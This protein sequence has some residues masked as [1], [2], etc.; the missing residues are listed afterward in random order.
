M[1]RD[2]TASPHIDLRELLGERQH[3]AGLSADG[4]GHLLLL[5]MEVE[6]ERNYLRSYRDGVTRFRLHH[7]VP[8]GIRTVEFHQPRDLF[9]LAQPLGEDH[10]LL[11]RGRSE[12]DDDPNAHLYTKSGKYVRSFPA[13]DGIADVQTT[14]G[15]AIWVSYFD[16]GV[17]S[18]SS[19]LGHAGLAC[20][21]ATDDDPLAYA[22]SFRFNQDLARYDGRGTPDITDCYA[23]NVTDEDVWLCYFGGFPLVRLSPDGRLRR[24]W[25]EAPV[26]GAK[27]IAT[28]G[29]KVLFAGSYDRKDRLFLWTPDNP[30]RVEELRAR[31]PD[32]EALTTR[33]L[34]LH[35]PIARGSR[36][37][38]ADDLARVYLI[39]LINL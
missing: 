5:S 9:S 4:D 8:P 19:D 6:G 13:G 37:Y 27:G 38:L 30:G 14:R 39:D 7:L 18:F 12:G 33:N 32:G 35:S 23:L 28:D 20:F 17:F 15:S 10:W 29:H 24:L 31:T 36:L 34:T 1:P 26:Q 16:E 3:V 25:R 11:V 2:I 21:T 22:A